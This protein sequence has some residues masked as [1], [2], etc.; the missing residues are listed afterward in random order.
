MR[1][2]LEARVGNRT[3]RFQEMLLAIAILGLGIQLTLTPDEVFKEGGALEPLLYFAPSFAWTLSWV[4][5]G[6]ARAVVVYINGVWPISPAVRWG[7]SI[8]SLGFWSF[9]AFGYWLMFPATKG[10]PMLVMGLVMVAVEANACYALSAMR[11]DRQ[12]AE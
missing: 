10:F 12:R 4:V 9:F 5:F 6:T 7:M 1:M 11:A 3:R 2:E 8:V